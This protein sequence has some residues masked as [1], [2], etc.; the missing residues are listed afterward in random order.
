MRDCIKSPNNAINCTETTEVPIRPTQNNDTNQAGAD[1]HSTQGGHTHS[2]NNSDKAGASTPLADT[3][4]WYKN[5][6]RFEC[7]QCGDC[8][9][10]GPGAVWV[11][12]EELTA[13]AAELHK[14]VGE[15]RLLHTKL[16]GSR[17]SLRDYPN[18]D[19]VFLDPQTRGCQIYA[20]RPI[21]CRTWPFWPSNI[22]STASWKRTC[23][24]CAGSGQGTLHSLEI[25][26]SQAERCDI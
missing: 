21:Q 14:T 1:S 18:G 4:P 3:I 25:I 26:R 22:E 12:D 16:I 20:V 19:C 6:L 2:I 7:T 13:I 24:V 8:C 10:G 11:T 5:G 15:V 23:D 17:W 9:T